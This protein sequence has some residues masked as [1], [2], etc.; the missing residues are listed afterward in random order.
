M[1]QNVLV[2]M[3]LQK[4]CLVWN[5]LSTR[6]PALLTVMDPVESPSMREQT[7]TLEGKGDLEALD[8][9]SKKLVTLQTIRHIVGAA[10]P[11]RTT[12]PQHQP[13]RTQPLGTMEVSG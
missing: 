12:L 10:V 1:K 6:F 3:S 4:V 2:K 11:M 13:I 7:T 8:T 5:L 9:T